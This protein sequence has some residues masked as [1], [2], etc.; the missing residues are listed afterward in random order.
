[1]NK[2]LDIE[3]MEEIQERL[4]D[5]KQQMEERAD[6]FIQAGKLEDD[7]DLMDEL[8]ELEAESAAHELEALEIGSG[9]IKGNAQPSQP[10]Y[11]PQAA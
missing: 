3:K 9:A 10:I 5:Q 6:F 1:M 2:Q 7:D 8:N 11:V 4:E